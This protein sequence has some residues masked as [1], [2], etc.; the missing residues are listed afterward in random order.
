MKEEKFP[1]SRKPCQKWVCREFWNLR[2]QHNQEKKK[3][4]SPQNMHLT[5]TSSG[6]MVQMLTSGTRERVWAGRCGL[7][8]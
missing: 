2:G 4:K 8:H 5:A 7:L 1:H 6:K 3:L